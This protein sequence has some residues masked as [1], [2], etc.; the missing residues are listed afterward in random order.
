VVWCE[1]GQVGG[2]SGARRKEGKK[3]GEGGS[4]GKVGVVEGLSRERGGI[5]VG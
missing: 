4:Y 5:G 1:E 2:G 3:G